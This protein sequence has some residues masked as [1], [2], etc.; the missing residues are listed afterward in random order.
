[1]KGR[2]ITSS[3]RALAANKATSGIFSPASLSK[4][5]LSSLFPAMPAHLEKTIDSYYDYKLKLQQIAEESILPKML[6]QAK[7][8][9]DEGKFSECKKAMAVI[10]HLIQEHGLERS[11][12]PS[13]L[14]LLAQAFYTNGLVKS[15]GDLQEQSDAE[16]NFKKAILLAGKCNDTEL[17]SS[18]DKQLRSLEL[19]RYALRGDEKFEFDDLSETTNSVS[20]H[21]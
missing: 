5:E 9:L 4:K 6:E 14:Q 11:C 18:A 21:N 20:K 1:M 17:K 10:M 19:S 8:N 12:S 7:L 2:R 15:Y 16:K 13:A 3:V